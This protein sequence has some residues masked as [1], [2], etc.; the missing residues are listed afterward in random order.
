MVTKEELEIA[1]NKI[2]EEVKNQSFEGT[3]EEIK[4]QQILWFDKYVKDNIEYGFDAVF[5]SI[6]HPN[7]INPYARA[8]R[9][10]GFF[11]QDKNSGERVAVCGSVSEVA[12]IVLKRLGIASDYVCGHFNIGTDIKPQYVGHRWNVVTIGDKNYMIDFTAGMIIHNLGKNEDYAYSALKLL[13][14][15]DE[16][17]EYD[18]ICFNKLAP[19]QSMGGFKK[20]ERNSTVDDKDELGFLNNINTDPNEVISNLG[21]I[22]PEVISEYAKRI[23]ANKSL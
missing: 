14:I 13:D 2:V 1:I 23:S 7:E 18:F 22:P 15:T 9:V 3:E 6:S 8:F 21:Y 12:N 17:R 16:E 4:L 10:E 20:N 5:F 19:S 11:E